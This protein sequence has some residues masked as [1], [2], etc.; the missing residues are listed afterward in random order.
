MDF[1]LKNYLKKFEKL[2][3]R[4]TKAR[5]AV[6]TAVEECVGVVL[7]RKKISISGANVFISGS[8]PLRS[9]IALKQ[10]KI[11]NKILELEPEIGIKNIK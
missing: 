2:T 9:E 3:P 1:N 10:A 5:N 6:I 4:E 11:L 7:D 8:S